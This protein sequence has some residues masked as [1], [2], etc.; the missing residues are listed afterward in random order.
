MLDPK[1]QLVLL[2]QDREVMAVTGM[3]EAEYRQFCLMAMQFSKPKPCQPQALGPFAVALINLA[4][5]LLLTGI[6]MLLAPAEQE[7]EKANYEESKVDGQ[8]V[9]RKDRFAPKNGFN[10]V[11]NVVELGSVVP[12]VYAKKEEIGGKQYGGIR[13]NS[14]MLWSQLLSIGGGQFFRGIFLISEKDVLLDHSQMALGNNTLASYELSPKD[15]KSEAGRVTYYFKDGGRIDKDDFE[16]GVIPA[17]DPGAFNQADIYE[18]EKSTHFCQAIQPS[19]QTEFGVFGHIGNNFGYKLGE[20]F[21]PTSQWQGDSNGK[22]ERQTSNQKRAELRKQAITFTTRAGFEGSSDAK[23]SVKKGQKLTYKIYSSSE[24]KRQFIGNGSNSGGETPS[25]VTSEDIGT[26]VASIQRSYDERINVGDLYK[27]GSAILICSDRTDPF[28]SEVDFKESDARSVTAEFTVIE[29]GEIW[30]WKSS[31]LDYDWNDVDEADK[32]FQVGVICSKYAQLYQLLVG[33]FSVERAF[34]TIEVGLQSNVALKSSGIPNF[35]S[36]VTREDKITGIDDV[37]NNSYQAYIDSE[38]CGGIEGNDGDSKENAYRKEIIA[39]KYSGQDTRYSF[40]RILYRENDDSGQTFTASNDLYGV[41]SVTGVDAYNYLRFKFTD[42]KRREFRFMPISSWEIREDIAQ[43]DLYFIDAHSQDPEK[44][45]SENGFDIQFLGDKID[46]SS[47]SFELKA[48]LNPNANEVQLSRSPHDDD[49]NKSYVD[50]WA[51]IA[52]AFIYDSVSTTASEP[53]HRISY[54]NIISENESVPSYAD[55]AIVGLNIRSS[56]ELR[57][58][59]Q[60]SVYVDRGVIDSHLFP[61]V[62]NDLLTDPRYGVGSFFSTDQ[63]DADSFAAAATWTNGRK[64]FFDGVISKKLNL[65]SWASDI[66]PHFLLDLSVSGGKFKLSPV[67]NFDGVEAVNAL[68][69]AG[70]IIEDS[71]EMNYFDTQDRLAPVVSVK[72]R[73]ERKDSSIDN[74]GLFPQI[75]EVLVRRKDTPDDAPEEQIDLS[76]F[77]TNEKHAIDRAKWLCQQRKYQ[78]H[79]VKFKTVPTEASI[80]AGS[81]IKVG[82]ETLKYD[83]PTAGCI[84]SDGTVQA[85]PMPAGDVQCLTWDGKTMLTETLNFAAGKVSGRS[86]LVFMATTSEVKSQGYKVQSIGFDED[87]NLDVEAVYWPLESDGSSS[88]LK[89]FGN[90]NFHIER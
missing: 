55:M 57:N 3:S 10:S 63:I 68:F 59:D 16:L 78:T 25:F 44:T 43:G 58:L 18:V 4:I 79:A 17:K 56:K 23:R 46:R 60:L 62:F 71:F 48:F 28:I 75:R 87:G 22:Y 15:E 11:Q 31:R 65:R 41:R 50:G 34:K 49:A 80:Q 54:V 82:L 81:I 12:I 13:V 1:A 42:S 45:I 69:T 20:S 77:C 61:E 37:P 53:E 73:E 14:N 7:P 35:N 39:G 38:Y 72:W 70:N 74:R 85:S 8:D 29:D 40:F 90:G 66:A 32:D 76:D 88:L 26:T 9:I 27:C 83:S 24:Y 33:S 84:T 5:G 19:N 89:D 2:P 30:E 47:D 86:N 67:V 52:E 51:R 6:S 36:L 64:Y 21:T